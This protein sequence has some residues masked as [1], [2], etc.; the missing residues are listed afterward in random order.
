MS[1]NLEIDPETGIL[2]VRSRGTAS[3]E[4]S[5]VQWR[6]IARELPAGPLKILNDRRE[7]EQVAEMDEVAAARGML[8]R[9]FELIPVSRVAVVV[10]EQA[11]YGMARMIQAYTDQ[12]PI[13]FRAFYDIDDAKAWLVSGD[14]S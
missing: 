10:Q 2:Y 14:D 8:K 9:F 5:L 4:D 11:A 6:K 3:G 1:E 12:L 7:V 13:E